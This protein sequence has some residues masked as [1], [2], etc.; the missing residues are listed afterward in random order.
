MKLK[1]LDWLY[2]VTEGRE[3]RTRLE[4]SDEGKE[5]GQGGMAKKK[6]C[7]KSETHGTMRLKSK[8]EHNDKE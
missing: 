1:K 3:G 4:K 2:E 5:R 8:G 6:G 7:E